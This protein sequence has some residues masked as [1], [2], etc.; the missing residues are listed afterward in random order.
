MIWQ[1]GFWVSSQ[2]YLKQGL[3]QILVYTGSW[4]KAHNSDVT[5]NFNLVFEVF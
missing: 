4:H 3:K 1:F 2:K 5:Y